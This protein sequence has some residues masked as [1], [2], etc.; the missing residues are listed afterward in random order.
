MRH[1]V[2]VFYYP[3]CKAVNPLQLFRFWVRAPVEYS[4]CGCTMAQYSKVKAALD[5]LENERRAIKSNRLALFAVSLKWNK[6][7]IVVSMGTPRCQTQD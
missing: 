3:Y 7:V 6:E 4:R 1:T 2:E 5:N